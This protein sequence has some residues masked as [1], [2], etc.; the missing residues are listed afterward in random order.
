ME[1]GIEVKIRESVE[2]VSFA[3]LKCVYSPVTISV[4][5][6]KALS[7]CLLLGFWGVGGGNNG[8]VRVGDSNSVWFKYWYFGSIGWCIIHISYNRRVDI[9]G[10]CSRIVIVF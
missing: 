4:Y 3:M 2:R 7:Q 10:G 1:G 6:S 5:L 9:I 8:R